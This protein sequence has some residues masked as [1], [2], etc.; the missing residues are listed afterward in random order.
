ML[1]VRRNTANI[2]SGYSKLYAMYVE[3]MHVCI[4]SVSCMYTL[5]IMYVYPRY[6][7]CIPSVSCMY[8]LGIMYVY[9][10]YHVCIPSVSCMYTLGIMYVYPRYHALRTHKFKVFSLYP[11]LSHDNNNIFLCDQKE[12]MI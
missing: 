1:S 5:G 6:H 8:T 2:Y 3:C 4:P 10:R 11:N 7:V 9:P 12:Y